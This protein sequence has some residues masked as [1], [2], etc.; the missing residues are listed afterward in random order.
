MS[1]ENET[2]TEELLKWEVFLHEHTLPHWEDIPDF[3]L[4]MEQVIVLLTGYLDFAPHNATEEQ[5]ITAATINNYVRK[6]LIPEPIKKKYYRVHIAYLIVICLIKYS[7]SIPNLHDLLQAEP[8][9]KDFRSVYEAYVQFHQAAMNFFVDHVH[10]AAAD[11]LDSKATSELGTGDVFELIAVSAII[12]CYSKLLT[13]K[14]LF[15][16]NKTPGDEGQIKEKVEL[17]AVPE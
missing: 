4:Y 7:L 14:L 15:L 9:K 10:P 6:K 8:A 3:G 13:E 12:G 5:F 11:V 1:N 16:K 2:I 17:D